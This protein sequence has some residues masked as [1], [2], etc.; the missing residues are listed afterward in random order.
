MPTNVRRGIYGRLSGDITLGNLLAPAAP[1][2]TKAIYHAVAPDGA[3]YPLVIFM[4][5]SGVPVEAMHDPEAYVESTWLVKA[6]DQNTTADTAEAIDA[7]VKALLNDASLSIS[8]A[9][10]LYLRRQSDVDYAEVT[11]G[12]TFR[13]SGGLYRLVYD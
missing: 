4:Q 1:G 5:T 3:T 11:N 10:S 6:I 7:R 8:G 9:V 2:Y 12:V 13:H